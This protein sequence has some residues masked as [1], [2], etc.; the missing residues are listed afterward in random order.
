MPISCAGQGAEAAAGLSPHIGP[1]V[2]FGTE[3]KPLHAGL[4]AKAG[5]T[6]ARLAR[7]GLRASAEALEGA[8]GFGEL[9]AG[10]TPADWS[11]ALPRQGEPLAIEWSGMAFKLWPSCGATHRA[12][13]GVLDLRRQHGFGADDVE[14]VVIEVS[15]G[16]LVNLRYAEPSDHKQ[17]QFSMPYAI[18]LALRFGGLSLADYTAE[19][20][21]DE[22]T[23]GL[24]PRVRMV[25]NPASVEGSES[26]SNH[27]P[28]RVT[29]RL[30][31]GRT[32]ERSVQHMK[33]G[34][35]DPLTP[36]DRRAKFDM[37]CAGVLPS[38]RLDAVRRMLS[39]PMEV[40]LRELMRN[41]MFPAGGDDGQRFKRGAPERLPA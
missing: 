10:V 7:S 20:V 41:L 25:K 1:K 33:G 9:Y 4:A 31:D 5:V 11:G 17:A 27:L 35:G 36:E 23:R 28:H 16:I 18:A 30:K 39:D 8:C 13:A 2:Q 21:R 34:L 29:V 37:C 3:A 19:A 26:A 24:M 12:I 22:A 14:S 6:A 15:H 32:L 38:G 40:P